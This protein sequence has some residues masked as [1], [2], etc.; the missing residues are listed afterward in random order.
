MAMQL[1]RASK[2]PLVA[3][4]GMAPTST[5]AVPQ[6]VTIATGVPT[7]LPAPKT[8]SVRAGESLV[9]I[10]RQYSCD[11]NVLAKANAL[12]A[13]AYP[14]RVGDVLRLEGCGR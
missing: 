2:D 10:A 3:S 1:M 13:P 7:V 14:V 8:H 9:A 5:F 4:V 6:G 11:F 12:R